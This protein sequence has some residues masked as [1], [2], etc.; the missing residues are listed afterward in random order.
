M[1]GSARVI[2]VVERQILY[3]GNPGMVVCVRRPFVEGAV[4][5]R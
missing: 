3:V 5:L 2:V 4:V 1:N